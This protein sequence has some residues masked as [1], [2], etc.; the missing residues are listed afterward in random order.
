M[1]TWSATEDKKAGKQ[2]L[3]EQK[4]RSGGAED[5]RGCFLLHTGTVWGGGPWRGRREQIRIRLDMAT[6]AIWERVQQTLAVPA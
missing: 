1:E 3:T 4:E 2:R 6:A 5:L